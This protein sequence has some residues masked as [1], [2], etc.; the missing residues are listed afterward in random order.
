MKEVI[1]KR[2]LCLQKGLQALSLREAADTAREGVE[3]EGGDLSGETGNHGV[4]GR[5]FS[6]ELEDEEWRMLTTN[7]PSWSHQESPAYPPPS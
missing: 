1:P 2:P 6:S 4:R 5:H 3:N 7:S